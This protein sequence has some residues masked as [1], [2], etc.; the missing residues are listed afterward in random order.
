VE[1]VRVEVMRGAVFVAPTRIGSGIRLKILEAMALQRPVV[2]TSVGC[3][4]I[5]AEPETHLLVADDPA[6]FADSVIRLL[7]DK[8]LQTSMTRNAA[9]LIEERYAWHTLAKQLSD[10]YEDIVRNKKDDA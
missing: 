4:G 2:S 9:R 5:E 7:E 1:D 10:T 8:S 3:E 6:I